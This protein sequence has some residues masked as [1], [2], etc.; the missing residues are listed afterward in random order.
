MD[1]NTVCTRPEARSRQ[2]SLGELVELV[3]SLVPEESVA[4]TVDALFERGIAS[5]ARCISTGKRADAVA[6]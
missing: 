5:F 3:A 1:L 2:L 4:D 6:N